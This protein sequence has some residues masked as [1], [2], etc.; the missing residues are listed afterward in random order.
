VHVIG[1][2]PTHV[3]F[4]H[5]SVCVHALL[6]SHGIPLVALPVSTHVCVPVMHD[7]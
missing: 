7:V 5:E 1:F 2:V 3:P 6:S 4:E